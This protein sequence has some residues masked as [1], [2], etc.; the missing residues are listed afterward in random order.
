MVERAK[1][2]LMQSLTLSEPEAF[3]RIQQAARNRNLRLADVARSV[4]EQQDIIQR[5][6]DA[7]AAR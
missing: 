5:P 2:L 7:D 1:A 3:R 6:A 4:L